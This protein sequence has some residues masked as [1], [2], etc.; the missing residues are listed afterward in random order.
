MMTDKKIDFKV[1]YSKIE[2]IYNEYNSKDPRYPMVLSVPHSGRTFPKEFLDNV[3]VNM[4]A[5]RSNEDPYI[6]ELIMEAS[7]C[8]IPMIS[9]NIGRAFIDVNRDTIEIDPSM[10]YNY[11]DTDI[12]AGNKRSRVGL[13]LFHRITSSRKNIYDGLLNY[14]EANERIKNVYNSY[15]SRLQKLIDKVVKKFGFCLVLDCHSMPSKICSIMQDN[16]QIEFCLG[17]LFEQ[18]CPS[19][20]H[21]FLM[22]H[23]SQKYNVSLDLPYSGAHI[24]FHYCQP[25][26]NVHT[27]QLEINRVLYIDETVYKKNQNFQYISTDTSHAI[28]DLANFLL[29]LTR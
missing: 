11:P 25:R 6:D 9:L 24:S 26:K 19:Y 28:I 4:D 21:E 17:T 1:N 3:A 16:H 15:H 22:N 10:F 23:L 20:I 2:P 18:S 5:L 27:L 14:H 29:D 12:I 7:D 13:G 8:G